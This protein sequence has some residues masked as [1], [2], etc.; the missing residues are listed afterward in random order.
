MS[1]TTAPTDQNSLVIQFLPMHKRAFGT[2]TGFTAALIIFLVTAATI[3]VHP[4]DAAD[5][6]L[7]AQFFAGYSLTWT[8][9][10]IG[11]A[12]AGFT[13]FVMGWFLAF[14]RNFFVA[15]TILYLRA[16]ADLAQS[17][18]LLDHI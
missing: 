4:D 11:A 17:R 3:I 1:G 8:G 14:T 13:G 9:A 12:W 18:D 16:R 5:L 7:L 15:G 2:A 10:L 6:G